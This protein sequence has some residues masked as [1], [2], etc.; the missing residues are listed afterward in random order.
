MLKRLKNLFTKNVPDTVIVDRSKLSP[1][2]RQFF[3]EIMKTSNER[4]V[5]DGKAEFLG[6]GT[7]EEYLEQQRKDD[8]T[9]KWYK[10]IGR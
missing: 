7:E 3:D 8:G 2:A 10:R 6:Q 9:D 1:E 4:L 5:G